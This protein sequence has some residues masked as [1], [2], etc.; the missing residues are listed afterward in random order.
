MCD[1]G[2]NLFI[3]APTRE[4]AKRVFWPDIKLLAGPTI[5]DKSESELWIELITGSRI[6]CI[7]FDKPERFDGSVWHGGIL[8]EYADMKP[9]VWGE[10]VY[11]ALIDTGGWCWFI[12]VPA[13]MNHFYDLIQ[14]AKER[15]DEDWVD[16]CWHSA[17]V[18]D[19]AEVERA[20][21]TMDPRTFRQELEG[22]FESYEG[23]AFA[24]YNPA[25]HRGAISFDRSHPLCVACD[26]NLD[27]CIWLLG[28]D[29]RGK[30]RVVGEIVQR[31]T[32]IFRMCVELWKR[33][34]TLGGGKLIFY[35]D[36]QHGTARSVSAVS[37]SWGILRGE[38]PRAEFRIKPNPRIIDGI[39]SVNAKLRNAKGETALII[40]PSA[41]ELH[42]DLNQVST[43]D[44]LDRTEG[45]GRGHAS[46]CLRYWMHYEYPIITG[47]KLE[48]M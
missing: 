41:V 21:A 19:P 40:D 30:I 24:Y 23:R 34:E 25:S 13:G 4:Q 27:P 3:G 1:P 48:V 22:S 31:R 36:Y 20:K 6:H 43:Q 47:G 18:I 11:P 37:S 45:S 10:H 2:V 44:I 5:S 29:V 15:N 7:G 17:D 26:F 12:G 33:Y 14:S 16:Y 38:F 8:D 39:N 42:K 35:G 46:S 9:E 32:D 28:Q